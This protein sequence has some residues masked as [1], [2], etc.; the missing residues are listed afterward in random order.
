MAHVVP[1]PA[2]AV[3]LTVVDRRLAHS[4]KSHADRDREADPGEIDDEAKVAV[5]PVPDGDQSVEC[6]RIAFVEAGDGEGADEFAIAD[7]IRSQ[8]WIEVI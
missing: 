3:C 6:G 5:E 7:M 1:A 8:G 2:A 4:V